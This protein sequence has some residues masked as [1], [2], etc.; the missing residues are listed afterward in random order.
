M[1]WK[2][3]GDRAYQE[4]KSY[5]EWACRVDGYIGELEIGSGKCIVIGDNVLLSTGISHGDTNSALV[6]C[7]ICFPHV[8]LVREGVIITIN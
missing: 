1:I 4:S 5:Y 7:Y 8:I 2:G 3:E 6:V